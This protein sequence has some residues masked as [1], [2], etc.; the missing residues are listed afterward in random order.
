MKYA[1]R[2]DNGVREQYAREDGA[3]LTFQ[4]SNAAENYGSRYLND[5]FEVVT[6]PDPS[7]LVRT[8]ENF[9]ASSMQ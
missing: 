4:S 6:W 7:S 2:L 1:I 8:G 5:P 9:F 3:L